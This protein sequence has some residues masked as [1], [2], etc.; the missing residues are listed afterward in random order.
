MTPILEVMRC[1]GLVVQ[2]GE[3]VIL[4]KDDAIVEAT[5]DD[6]EDD[7]ILSPTNLAILNLENP[8]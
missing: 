3:E 8:P 7:G 4:E 5:S 2:E 1:S 6:D